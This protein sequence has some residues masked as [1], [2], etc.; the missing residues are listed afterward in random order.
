MCPSGGVTHFYLR[1]S[2]YK[3]RAR[4][5]AL[6]RESSACH[7]TRCLSFSSARSVQERRRHD[8][9]RTAADHRVRHG[10][11]KEL[12]FNLF[13]RRVHFVM[14]MKVNTS[15]RSRGALEERTR[16]APVATPWQDA[17]A[18]SR[19]DP[20]VLL[21]MRVSLSRLPR[22]A[23]LTPRPPERPAGW[24]TAGPL[25]GLEAPELGVLSLVS[26]CGCDASPRAARCA[27]RGRRSR[28]QADPRHR[29][30]G[31]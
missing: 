10:T 4:L 6:Q 1:C 29:K 17:R 13:Q 5:D 8:N 28:T 14:D 31:V 9:S 15:M 2:K 20:C 7:R 23:A 19:P 24:L 27:L 11:Q 12:F 18:R 30:G 21:L 22:S 3:L 25:N 16:R 26:P